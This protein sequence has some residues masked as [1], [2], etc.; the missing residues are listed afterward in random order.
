MKFLKKFLIYVIFVFSFVSTQAF[1]YEPN[2]DI[3]DDLNNIKESFIKISSYSKIKSDSIP[4]DIFVIIQNSF[5]FLKDKLPQVPNFKVIYESCYISSKEL[6]N[7]FEKTKFDK[8]NSECFWPWQSISQEIF[9]KY[10]VQADIKAY[11]SDWNAPLN[12]TFDGRNSKDPSSDTIPTNNYYWYYKDNK[13]VT[14][15]MW[16]W[17]LINYDFDEPNDYIVHLTVKSSNKEKRWILDWSD[18]ITVSVAPA[19]A[20]LSLYINWQRANKNDYIKL[21]SEEWKNWVIFNGNWTVPRW[22]TKIT[23]SYWIIKGWNKIIYEKE[24]PDYPWSVKVKLNEDWIYFVTLW[25]KDNTWKKVEWTYKVIVSNPISLIKVNPS[26]WDTST[27]FTIDGSPSYSVNWKIDK[28]KWTIVWPDWNRIDSFE[29]KKNFT[30][31]FKTPWIYAITLEIVDIN[32]DKNQ[33]TYK[34]NVESTFPI[35]NFI[36]EKYD[37]WENPSTFI[38]DA[39]YS[40]DVDEKYQDNLSYIWSFT[41]SQNVKTQIINNWEKLIAQFNKIWTYKVTLTVKDKYSKISSITKDIEIKSTLRPQISINPNYTII[42]EP[43]S[44]KVDTNKS[45]AYYEYFFWDNIDLK[46]QSNIVEHTYNKA[47]VYELKVIVSSIDGD[48]NSITKK[49]FIWQRWYPLAIY[50]VYK[51][52]NQQLPS[53]Y[54]KIKKEIWTWVK[55]IPAYEIE[56]MENFKIDANK[57]INSQ[58]MNNML[59]IY[60]KKDNNSSENIIKSVLDIN[61]DELWCQKIEL[62]VRDLNTNKIDKQDIYLKVVNAKPILKWLYMYFPQYWWDQSNNTVFKLNIWYNNNDTS[63]DLF[64]A[65]FDPLLVKLIVQ[66]AQDPDNAIIWYYKWYYYRKWDETNFIDVKQTPYNINQVVFP[67]SRIPWEYIFWLNVC[68]VDWECTNSEEYLQS[69]LIVTIPP[70]ADNPNIPQI[71][72][73]R[74]DKWEQ[75]WIWEVNVWDKVDIVVNSQILSNNTDF[76]SSSTIK[77]D[78]DNDWKYDLTT[79]KNKVEHTFT[80]PWKYKVKVKVIYRWY[81]WI[82]YSQDIVVKKW[83]KPMIDINYNWWNLIYND[84]SFWNIKEKDFCFSI[85]DCKTLPADFLFKNSDYGIITYQNTWNKFLSFTI[86]DEY[87]NEKSVKKKINIKDLWKFLLTLPAYIESWD[88]YYVASAWMYKDYIMFYYGS[89]NKNCY[90]DKNITIDS[91]NDWNTLNDK[92]LSCNSIYKLKYE[93]VPE[94][95]LLINDEGKSRKLQIDFVDFQLSLPSEYKQQYEKIQ[96]LIDK[97]SKEEGN[98]YLVKLLSDLLNNLDDKVDKDAILFEIDTYINS[99]NVESKDTIKSII[100]S[101]SDENVKS[102]I[103]IDSTVFWTFRTDVDILLKDGTNDQQ[104][105]DLLDKFENVNSKDERK[106]ILQNILNIW[107]EMEKSWK[108]SSDELNSLKQSICNVMSNYEIPSE[109]CWTWIDEKWVV[110]KWWST[111]WTIIK[112]VLQI[113]AIFVVIFIII[114]VIFVVKAKMNRDKNK[115]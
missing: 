26:N 71:N 17:P 106:D 65:S 25:I 82:W 43:I 84:L 91:D 58:W 39:S 110:N 78:F 10:T 21:S 36:Y 108:L 88:N 13:W 101:I 22:K 85:K 75:K 66:W 16:Q 81:G 74:I 68:D 97:Y 107:I 11:P 52:Q 28:Y 63:K 72:S 76:L 34:L 69:K 113:L 5:D 1:Y 67:L 96:K 105:N 35:A 37:N 94:V 18:D 104:I 29:N 86:K 14:K 80:T 30:Y 102:A 47:W 64:K 6:S 70:S 50:S 79:K 109:A 87:G 89:K 51:W 93:N 56:R 40:S 111:L 98:E 62:Y 54:C 90:V 41:D 8:F 48:T 27:K 12:V 33:E 2:S 9:S 49:V 53:T 92:D 99:N 57:S 46:T 112:I 23:S 61:F 55:Y 73:V 19:I 3:D 115:E 95:I 24:I 77:Y 4:N 7:G 60:F 42:S 83:L 44:I 20:N 100:L 114:V 59:S 45:V 31:N 15:L 32:W 38:F 103:F